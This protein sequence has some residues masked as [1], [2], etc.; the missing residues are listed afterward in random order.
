MLKAVSSCVVAVLL[1]VTLVACAPG[2]PAVPDAPSKTPVTVWPGLTARIQPTWTVTANL[3]G[4]TAVS[5][6]VVVSY[7]NGGE[8]TL[9]VVAWDVAS[10]AE[11]WRD[12]ASF[13]SIP[14]NADGSATLVDIDGVQLVVYLQDDATEDSGR[15]LVIAADLHTGSHWDGGN[16]VVD[17]TSLPADCADSAGICLHGRILVSPNDSDQ[18]VRVDPTTKQ[19]EVEEGESSRPNARSLG[20]EIYSTLDRAPDGIEML[21]YGAPEASVWER[22]YTDVFGSGYSSDRGGYWLDVR[23]DVGRDFAVGVGYPTDPAASDAQTA[24]FDMRK[25]IIVGLD[26]ASGRTVW[27]VTAAD[28]G[29]DA[30]RID[31]SLVTTVIPVCMFASGLVIADRSNPEHTT[32]TSS[33][34]DARIVGLDSAT[35]DELWSIDAGSDPALLRNSTRFVSWLAVRPIRIDK[36]LWMV[37]VLSGEKTAIPNGAGFACEYERNPFTVHIP[38]PTVTQTVRYSTG[39]GVVACDSDRT[40]IPDGFSPGALEMAAIDAGGG[41]SIVAGRDSLLGFRLD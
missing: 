7:V 41:L 8:D 37:D 25:N 22:P 11:L 36:T 35:G 29:C 34:V 12:A 24:T 26:P 32:V 19:L 5:E 2:V 16:L 40:E 31:S 21:G 39:M 9:Q 38:G 13:G 14:Q 23:G 20:G 4:A 28:R 10:G 1:F 18:P 17:A 3:V 6:G 30:V 27:K 33:T 15:Q